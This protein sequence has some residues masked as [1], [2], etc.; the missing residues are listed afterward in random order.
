MSTSES[1]S[2][3]GDF[4]VTESEDSDDMSTAQPIR[5][6]GRVRRLTN[7]PPIQIPH[8]RPRRN[9]DPP[10]SYE[11]PG[12]SSF[13]E[14]MGDSNDDDDDEDDEDDDEDEDDEEDD[15]DVKDISSEDSDAD[16]NEDSGSD[17]VALKIKTKTSKKGSPSGKKLP[18]DSPRDTDDTPRTKFDMSQFWNSE[19]VEQYFDE[20]DHVSSTDI[21]KQMQAL[22]SLENEYGGSQNVD[23]NGNP[24]NY[25][26]N[27]STVQVLDIQDMLDEHDQNDED[28]TNIE[29]VEERRKEMEKDPDDEDH[30]QQNHIT[31]FI[32]TSA[33]S[34]IIE[35]SADNGRRVIGRTREWKKQEDVEAME[36]TLLDYILEEDLLS[37]YL[38]I[39]LNENKTNINQLIQYH[40]ASLSSLSSRANHSNGTNG[41]NG[42]TPFIT[43]RRPGGED[44]LAPDGN[45]LFP[46]L[47]SSF[48]TTHPFSS[49]VSAALFPTTTSS[50]RT[51]I[52]YPINPTTNA[53]ELELVSAYQQV[54][55]TQ[56]IKKCIISG[57][58]DRD[59]KFN[60]LQLE[61]DG[62]IFDEEDDVLC[63]VC[64]S[65]ESG[66]SNQILYCDRCNVPVHQCCYGIPEVPEG[67][68]YCDV[69]TTL[70][71]AWPSNKTKQLALYETTM[72]CS[73]CGLR[74]GAMKP[75]VSPLEDELKK[76]HEQRKLKKAS[77]RQRKASSEEIDYNEHSDSEEDDDRPPPTAWV[78]VTCAMICGDVNVQNYRI[79]G[80][81]SKA[82]Q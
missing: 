66:E 17:W 69:C 39:Q 62:D 82:T 30:K 63:Q 22:T 70:R 79:M 53:S 76:E 8:D 55:A 64:Y 9:V 61:R 5:R 59:P 42:T 36:E 15:D 7:P 56:R 2:S 3:D 21:E 11:D 46:N 16:E 47:S 75:V 71:R 19:D 43:N 65:G 34:A 57:V 73:I 41:T 10:V 1:E 58:V 48:R 35:L 31:T 49:S 78:H 52:S 28:W 80:K 33:G 60:R 37:D 72:F 4:S 26:P 20:L 29:G 45:P 50:L 40:R 44:V 14:R 12:S 54:M 77:L 32:S 18:N 51:S 68:F 38:S 25:V 23:V 24:T 67:D 6:G 27:T 81:Y 74:H 13:E